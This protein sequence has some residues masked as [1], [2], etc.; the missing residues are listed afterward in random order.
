M[1]KDWMHV[2]NTSYE[3]YYKAIFSSFNAVMNFLF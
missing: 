1:K 3:R 2:I